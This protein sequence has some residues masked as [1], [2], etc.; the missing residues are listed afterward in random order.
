M[1]DNCV[2]DPLGMHR[3]QGTCEEGGRPLGTQ[4]C[5]TSLGWGVVG[6]SGPNCEELD[7]ASHHF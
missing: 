3:E 1:R 5:N 2:F 4:L 7:V 6:S